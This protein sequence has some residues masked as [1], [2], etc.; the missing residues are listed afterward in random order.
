MSVHDHSAP[1]NTFS[2]DVGGEPEPP[3]SIELEQALLG[4]LLTDNGVAD[5]VRDTVSSDDFFDPLHASIWERAGELIASGQTADPRTLRRSFET[6]MITDEMPVH[7]YL[8]TLVA[9]ATSIVSAPDYA[10]AIADLAVRRRLIDLG[11]ELA[12]G[13]SDL[14]PTADLLDDLGRR[15]SLI[16]SGSARNRAVSLGA[17]A[18]AAMKRLAQAYKLRQPVGVSTGIADLD[19]RIGKLK[20]GHLYVLA[21]RPAMGKTGLALNIAYA[22]AT[23]R[24]VDEHGEEQDPRTVMFF[25]LEMPADQ[26]AERI[27]AERAEVSG[28]RLAA[29]SIDQAEFESVIEASRRLGTV[30]LEIDESSGITIASLAARARR[31]NAEDGPLGLVVVD[32]LGLL[33]GTS[34]RSADNRVQEITEI[35]T[36][37]KALAKEL[38][39]P[40]L[41][42][43]QLNRGVESRT[44]KRPSLSD[45]R[46]SGSIEQ[47]ADVVLFVY[48]D[49]YYAERSAPDPGDLDAYEAWE[50][51]VRA[52]AG[53]AEL[54]VAK[55]RHGPTGTVHA[56]FDAKLMRFSDLA[57]TERATAGRYGHD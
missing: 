56:A 36:G 18:E 13:A 52:A 45:L 5:R 29:G 32:Y 10:T 39:V 57:I 49:E 6:V 11:A 22:A 27:L 14:R 2:P 16:A 50:A 28:A 9:A 35:T 12:A 44:D 43:S 23:R 51:R 3:H 55:N 17:A 4:A 41:A 38:R 33:R 20:P 37:L 15:V 19:A 1:V 34:R 31:Q 25:S 21:G 26:L 54:I 30:P 47:D 7:R 8:G 53:K 46:E 24:W 42:L 40:V 48:R